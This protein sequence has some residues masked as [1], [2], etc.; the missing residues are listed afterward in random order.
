MEA[1]HGAR[2]EDGGIH[3]AASPFIV[4]AA[5]GSSLKT[6]EIMMGSS[7]NTLETQLKGYRCLLEEGG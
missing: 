2:L 7:E 3:P 6:R 4:L 5:V 1:W